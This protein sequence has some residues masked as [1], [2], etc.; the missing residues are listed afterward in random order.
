MRVG[1]PCGKSNPRSDEATARSGRATRIRWAGAMVNQGR[2]L[3]HERCCPSDRGCTIMTLRTITRLSA[4]G[5]HDRPQQSWFVRDS[6]CIDLSHL[7]APRSGSSPS[8]H[9]SAPTAPI[10]APK[11]LFPALAS[12]RRCSRPQQVPASLL[13]SVAACTLAGFCRWIS[14]SFR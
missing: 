10:S 3:S 1:L 14:R 6:D 5:V 9:T 8:L 4:V 12:L 2:Q 11:R 13:R 7:L